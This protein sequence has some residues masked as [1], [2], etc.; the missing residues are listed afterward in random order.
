[1]QRDHW[2]VK[3]SKCVFAQR[4]L[5]YLGH[6]ISKRGVATDL[7]KVATVSQWPVP[8]TVKD[9]RSFLGLAGYYRRFVKHFSV[10]T[11][12]LNDLLKKGAIFLWTTVHDQA[13]QALKEALISAPVLALPDFTKPFC[14]ET[15][16]SG[17]GIGAVLTQA[18]HPLAYLSKT[19]SP[20]SQGLS[21]YE[22]EHLAIQL[23]LDHWRCYLQ[24]A[25]F[26][27]LTHHK[28][29]SQLTEQRLHTPR[30]QKVFTK[31]V[32]LQFR[33]VYRQGAENRV[34]DALS[35]LLPSQC[36]A[37]SSVQPQW[38]SEVTASY[39]HD[40]RAQEIITKLAVDS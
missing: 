9:L 21:T 18:G 6:V 24:Y 19:L 2:Q 36:A 7:E 28:S 14:V 29:L 39:A 30:Q 12:P 10:I 25:E 35:R 1:L 34:T 13:F 3:L 8:T 17:T 16:A 15:D 5:K 31:L 22:K 27:I 26:T 32:G 4:Q 33:I 40:S 37:I 23:A 38:L 20:R 11:R